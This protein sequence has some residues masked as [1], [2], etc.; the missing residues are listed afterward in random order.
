[1][2][3]DDIKLYGT[4]WCPKTALLKN[5]FQAE[6]ID[7]EYYNV[8]E[9]EDAKQELMDIYDGKVKFPTIT[10]GGEHVKNPSVG[11]VRKFLKEDK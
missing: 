3:K 1:M 9:D 4:D 11:D 5:F 7:F 6:W 2:G 8:D 10:K